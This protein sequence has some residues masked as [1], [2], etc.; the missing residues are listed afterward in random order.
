MSQN[1]QTHF[2]K[3]FWSVFDHFGILCIKGLKNGDAI[4]NTWESVF[5]IVPKMNVSNAISTSR[6]LE[7][8]NINIVRSDGLPVWFVLNKFVTIKFVNKTPSI[9]VTQIPANIA[10]WSLDMLAKYILYKWPLW[11]IFDLFV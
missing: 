11:K 6:T 7:K 8:L 2:K 9:T 10:F 4:C 5:V 1:G 3:K